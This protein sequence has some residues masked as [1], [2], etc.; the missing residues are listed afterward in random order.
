MRSIDFENLESV[1]LDAI[2]KGAGLQEMFDGV[3]SCLKLPLICFDTT[4]HMLAYAFPR[5]FSGAFQ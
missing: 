2:L 3:Y 4:F 1:L 5:P